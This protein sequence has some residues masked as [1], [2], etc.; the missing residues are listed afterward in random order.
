MLSQ[1]IALNH[2]AIAGC[3][4]LNTSEYEPRAING[5]KQKKKNPSS[6][7]WK[8]M[9]EVDCRGGNDCYKH[10]IL[11]NGTWC[12]KKFYCSQH[13][14]PLWQVICAHCDFLSQGRLLILASGMEGTGAC[15]VHQWY[16]CTPLTAPNVSRARADSLNAGRGKKQN[17]ADVKKI[18]CFFGA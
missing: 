7:L 4:F 8:A 16:E 11:Q 14:V 3:P 9:C 13:A 10:T 17:K 2:I 18:L 5:L 1:L 6:C 12:W 15:S